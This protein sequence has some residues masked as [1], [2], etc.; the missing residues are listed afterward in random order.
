MPRK[1]TDLLDVFRLSD[2]RATPPEKPS[3][4]RKGS[5]GRSREKGARFEGIYLIPRH[6]LLG[7]S[8]VALLLVL[9]F[10]VGIGVGRSGREARPAA[11]ALQRPAA[12]WMLV[13]QMSDRERMDLARTQ[14]LANDQ[15][16]R[17]LET[18]YRVPRA[19]MQVVNG[20]GVTEIR[21][22]PFASPSDA[23]TFLDDRGLR[24]ARIGSASPFKHGR[25]VPYP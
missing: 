24:T 15:I 11:P 23:Q 8:V 22:G 1:A 21:I 12:R 5:G 9:A 17:D 25:A 2:Q 6:L 4:G 16:L 10:T 3:R 20:P 14:E 13:G 7:G 19:R 18:R